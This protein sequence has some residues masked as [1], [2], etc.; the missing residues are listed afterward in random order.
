MNH[1]K[2]WSELALTFLFLIPK[3]SILIKS[4]AIPHP[5]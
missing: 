1:F 2:G 5:K 3:E 4:L